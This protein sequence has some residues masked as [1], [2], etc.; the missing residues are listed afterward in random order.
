MS[1]E[2]PKE[3]RVLAYSMANEL[4]LGY[5]TLNGN[6][7]TFKDGGIMTM[8]A[9]DSP[10]NLFF[11]KYIFNIKTFQ[12]EGNLLRLYYT[13]EDY[14]IFTNE[15]TASNVQ[16]SGCLEETRADAEEY[17]KTIILT[18]EGDILTVQLHNYESN[19][20]TT[21]FDVTHGMSW[22]ITGI[23]YSIYV[24]VK[25]IS[26]NEKDC[27]CP[28][29][30]T[31]TIDNVTDNSF[32]FVCWWYDGLV[33]LIDGKSLV[34]NEDVNIDVEGLIYTLDDESF[35]AKLINGKTWEGELS[36]P[37]EIEWKGQKYVV[38]SIGQKAFEGCK[39]LTS[40]SIPKSITT[41]RYAAFHEC[42]SLTNIS[43]PDGVTTI[44]N[45][46]FFSCNNLTSVVL[47]ENLTSI[48]ERTFEDCMSLTNIII[49][50]SVTT[51]GYGAFYCCR[52]LPKITIP[53]S[54]TNIG[55]DA[56]ENCI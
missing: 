17:K 23:P 30:V 28:Y 38:N 1:I 50:N 54:V 36:I 29:N 42:Y 43:I 34:L 5:L 18:K 55:R 12:L 4:I 33:N 45:S 6:E 46:V 8:V 44:G 13:D 2:I 15:P 21:D 11:E 7:M 16:H 47:S 20:G 32:R 56:F 24:T 14:F 53:D 35:T 31:Y 52:S 25:P 41:I 3:G 39:G 51:I 37:S 22:S 27:M 49:P 48:N 10:K 9:Y 19:C 26:E 40:I